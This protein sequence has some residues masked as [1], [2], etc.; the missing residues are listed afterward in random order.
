MDL[1]AGQQRALFAVIVVVLAGL[2]IFLITSHGSK[3]P[4]ASGPPSSSPS[5]PAQAAGSPSAVP[6]PTGAAGNASVNI[7]QWLPFTQPDL[8]RAAAVTTQVTTDY[9][10]FT[11]TQSAASYVAQM[12]G[13]ITSQLGQTLQNGFSTLGVARARTSQKQVSTGSAAI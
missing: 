13:L 7:Y 10:T 2:G 3:R 9:N 1:S 5:P 6:S 4:A 12:N 11:Y 8:A